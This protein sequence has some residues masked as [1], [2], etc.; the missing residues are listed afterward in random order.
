MDAVPIGVRALDLD[1][2]D[3]QRNRPERE[4]LIDEGTTSGAHECGMGTAYS[5]GG[6]SEVG[7][8]YFTHKRHADRAADLLKCL[9]RRPRALS[10]PLF[11]SA[12]SSHLPNA[13]MGHFIR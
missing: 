7:E 5:R 12:R 1:K 3:K 11:E 13:N 4:D 10:R 2:R 6:S 8:E 9:E